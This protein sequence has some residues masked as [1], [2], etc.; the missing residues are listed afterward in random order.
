MSVD[1]HVDPKMENLTKGIGGA[2]KARSNKFLPS[3]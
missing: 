3:T 2:G 1:I